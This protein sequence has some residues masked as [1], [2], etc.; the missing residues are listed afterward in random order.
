MTRT[1]FWQTKIQSNRLRDSNA[2]GRL[3]A[4]G[5]N[6]IVVWECALKTANARGADFM[7]DIGR[8]LKSFKENPSPT[9]A[10]VSMRPIM[11]SVVTSLAIP[12]AHIAFQQ[13]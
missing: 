11:L 6:V 8:L 3:A 1:D 10:E 5:W 9:F 4:D 2:I 12:S 7:V 13:R